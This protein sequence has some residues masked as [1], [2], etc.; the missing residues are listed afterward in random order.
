[1]DEVQKYNS[2]KNIRDMYSSIN[3][4]KKGYHPRITTIKDENDNLLANT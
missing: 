2:F 4:F 3:E 1:M